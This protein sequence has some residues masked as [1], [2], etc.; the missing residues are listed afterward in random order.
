VP[1]V[2]NPNT[3]NNEITIKEVMEIEE[4]HDLFNLP[5]PEEA[6]EQYCELGILLQLK[7][8]NIQKDKWT[9]I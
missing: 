9:Y 7:R 4:L 6:C 3:I 2:S 8:K 5:L 1:W